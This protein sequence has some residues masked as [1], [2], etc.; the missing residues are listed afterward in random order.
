[1]GNIPCK[2]YTLLLMPIQ[3]LKNG[4]AY[5]VDTFRQKNITTLAKCNEDTHFVKATQC[6]NFET[7]KIYLT[8]HSV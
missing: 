6:Q 8:M 3:H 1:M 7:S 5:T 4:I 2:P